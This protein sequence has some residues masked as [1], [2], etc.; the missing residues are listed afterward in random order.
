MFLWPKYDHFKDKEIV[1]CDSL[2]GT[3]DGVPY[4]LFCMKEPD[5]V[6]KIMSTYGGLTEKEDQRDSHRAHIVNGEVQ[7][8]T[9]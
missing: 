2:Q 8:T 4:D 9:F 5:Y 7:N 6:M 3:L 1:E